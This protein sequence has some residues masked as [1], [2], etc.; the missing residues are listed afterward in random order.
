MDFLIDNNVEFKQ[1]E[2]DGGY[3]ATVRILNQQVTSKPHIING[4]E[5]MR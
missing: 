4:M 2:N 5:E 3:T 1:D